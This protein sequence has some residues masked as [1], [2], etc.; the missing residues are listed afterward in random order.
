MYDDP[1]Q[2][3]ECL[4]CGILGQEILVLF[5]QPLGPSTTVKSLVKML[6]STTDSLIKIYETTNKRNKYEENNVLKNEKVFKRNH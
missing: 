6:P 5:L 2:F 3:Q 4:T 1:A